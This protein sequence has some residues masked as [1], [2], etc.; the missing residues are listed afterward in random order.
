MFASI[1]NRLEDVVSAYGNDVAIVSDDDN[2]CTYNDLM[3]RIKS[4]SGYMYKLNLR[5]GDRVSILLN[6]SIE[7][8]LSLLTMPFFQLVG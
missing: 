3:S 7:L 2:V 1:Y 8:N 4:L 6:N 5:K